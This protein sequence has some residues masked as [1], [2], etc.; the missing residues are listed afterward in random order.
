[1][2]PVRAALGSIEVW[3]Y[4]L[5]VLITIG[6]IVAMVFVAGRVYA[7]GILQFGGKIKLRDAWRSAGQ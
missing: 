2:V 1:V 4:V 6:T 3:E 5:A 7:G